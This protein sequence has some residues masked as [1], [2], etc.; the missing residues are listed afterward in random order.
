MKPALFD[1]FRPSTLEEALQ[2]LSAH[3]QGG[4]LI[5]GGQSLVPILNMRLSAPEC[6]IDI[7]GLQELDYVR[8]EDGWLRIGALTR[9]REVERSRL[10]REKIPLLSEAVPFIGHMQT[11]NRGTIGGS[12]VHADPTAELPLSLLALN[13]SAVIQS[14]DETREVDLREFFITYLTTDIMPGELLTEVKVPVDSVPKGYSFHEFSRRHGD[15]ALVAA[16]C[17]LDSDPQGRILTARITL[18]GV[19][20]IPVLA[21]DAAGILIGEKLTDTLLEEVGRMAAMNVDPEGD[22]HATR[23]YRLHLAGVFAKRAVKT[24]YIRATGKEGAL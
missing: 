6:L 22:L 4:K 18:G 20:S 21:E 23:E 3:G 9:Q 15:F 10:I 1:Y 24:A 13:G 16:A 11:R 2:L 19:D 5:A 17:V 8:Y 14:A 7:N 12:I